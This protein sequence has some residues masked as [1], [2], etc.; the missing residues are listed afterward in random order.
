MKSPT[1]DFPIL[2][3]VVAVASDRIER[4]GHPSHAV[5]YVRARNGQR[6]RIQHTAARRTGYWTKG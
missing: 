1:P 6:C 3:P 2:R 4:H 5:P